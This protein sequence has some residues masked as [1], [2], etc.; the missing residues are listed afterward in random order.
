V[1]LGLG[2]RVQGV[3]NSIAVLGYMSFGFGVRV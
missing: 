1:R 3:G 2:F